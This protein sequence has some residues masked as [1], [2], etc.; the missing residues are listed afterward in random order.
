MKFPILWYKYW[1]SSRWSIF[2]GCS[3]ARRL[4]IPN[5]KFLASV[6]WDT[7]IYT[8]SL[9]RCDYLNFWSIEC[10]IGG[11]MMPL[12]NVVHKNHK[13]HNIQISKITIFV[14]SKTQKH[15]KTILRAIKKTAGVET[16]VL[17]SET[18]RTT[19]ISFCFVSNIVFN[20]VWL[21]RKS[22]ISLK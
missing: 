16:L 4:Q 8:Y 11:P 6:F 18:Y 14:N 7:I 19:F 1:R 20:K 5:L 15:V 3:T 12:W 21:Y 10:A 2:S 17:C 13:I 22:R 9:F